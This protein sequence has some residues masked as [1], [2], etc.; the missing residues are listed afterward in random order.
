MIE[1]GEERT[2]RT[3]LLCSAIAVCSLVQVI[4]E[5]PAD[6]SETTESEIIFRELSA[7][8][9][10]D[11][12]RAKSARLELE[13]WH[14]SSRKSAIRQSVKTKDGKNVEVFFLNDLTY[15]LPGYAFS[16]AFVTVENR[17]IDWASCW[18]STRSAR[19]KLQLEDV[20]K[21][22]FL[23]VAFQADKGFFGL[24][25]QRVHSRPGV[26]GKWFYAYSLSGQGFQSLFPSTTR[27]VTVRVS[28]DTANQPV[29]LEVKDLPKLLRVYQLIECTITAT[30]T[31]ENNLALNPDGWFALE[32][33][34]GGYVMTCKRSDRQTLKPKESI[35]QSVQLVVTEPEH[36]FDVQWKFVPNEP[37]KTSP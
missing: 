28:Y 21:D 1:L 36:D 4:A 12:E 19:Q 18:T 13:Y 16:L 9:P 20:D 34:H 5:E 23:D 33:K 32:S 31:T 14:G 35:S 26:E 6:K 22:G 15:S 10:K 30:N 7:G 27:E 2:L 37:E 11:T 24:R 8:L 3:F 25:D 29:T 17:V